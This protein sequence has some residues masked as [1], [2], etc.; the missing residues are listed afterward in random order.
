VKK[1]SRREFVAA[2]A[3]AIALSAAIFKS[4]QGWLTTVGQ[5]AGYGVERTL[6]EPMT[7]PAGAEIDPV[8]HALNRLTFGPGPGDHARVSAM[9]VKAFIEEQLAPDAI[10]DSLCDRATARFGDLWNEPLG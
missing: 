6:H 5:Y 2:G 4:T 7:P 3:G 1:T 9:G 8:S 10:G